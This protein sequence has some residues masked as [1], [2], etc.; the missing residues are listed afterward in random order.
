MR[1]LITYFVK[2][3]I[4]ANI[5]I[6]VTLIGGIL[7]FVSTKK[8][9]LPDLEVQ[10]I[11]ISVAYPG[12]SPEEME[13]GVTL[14]IE[15][16]IKN[17]AGIDEITST[18][19]ENSARISV[20]TLTNYDIDEIFTEIKNAVDGVSS[21]P[22]NA[23][24]PLMFKIKPTIPAAWLGL[25][26]D[27]DL[28]TLK[29]F[30]ESVEDD[31]IASGVISKVALMGFPPREISI[32]VSEEMLLR[33]GLRFDEVAAAVRNNNR[34]I[35]AGSIKSTEEEILIRSRGKKQRSS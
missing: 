2:Y 15:E 8:A 11:S 30:G 18:S 10:N 27:V 6:G 24:R 21:F 23:E 17:I 13:E 22:A 35:S 3:P 9:F 1:K 12:A 28:A 26:G 25:T 20:S 4:V 7:A 32:E 31:L 16:A 14:K 5:V 19:S 33:Y 34:D 29:S